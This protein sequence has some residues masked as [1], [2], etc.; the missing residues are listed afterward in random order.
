LRS[1]ETSASN[2][3]RARTVLD[4]GAGTDLLGDLHGLG[5]KA[6]DPAVG[7]PVGLD[8]RIEVRLVEGA[9]AARSSVTGTSSIHE[10]SL[11]WM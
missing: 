7:A 3:S 10:S 6:L 9:V 1:C 2:S 4:L 11:A 8:H 5:E